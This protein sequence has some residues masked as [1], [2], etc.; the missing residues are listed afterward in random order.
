MGASNV[1]RVYL[2]W[3]TL[4]KDRP[5]RLLVFMALHSRDHDQEPWFGMRHE[6]LAEFA[7]G[8]QVAKDGPERD[9]TLRIVRRHVTPLFA[10]GAIQ[11]TR[12]ATTGGM[13]VRPVVYR[14]Y[15]DGPWRSSPFPDR[16]PG[17][18]TP[19]PDPGEP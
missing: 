5:F 1:G 14:L 12:R 19:A 11:T 9:K 13:G 10:L 2:G 6:D 7:L 16:E 8:L 17:R 15:L 3:G 4:L 18:W